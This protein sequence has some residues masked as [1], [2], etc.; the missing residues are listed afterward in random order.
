M[1]GYPLFVTGHPSNVKIHFTKG[2]IYSR[3]RRNGPLFE[4]IKLK[5]EQGRRREES[6]LYIHG[7]CLVMA[8][9]QRR[10]V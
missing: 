6:Q 2:A 8:A 9:W 7:W 4:D 3:Y 1:D 5:K 10:A